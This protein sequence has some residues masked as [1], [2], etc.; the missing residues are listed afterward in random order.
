MA[1]RRRVGTST[2]MGNVCLFGDFHLCSTTSHS[3]PR[4]LTRF[5]SLLA[6]GLFVP[7][8]F[9]TAGTS[10][11]HIAASRVTT[12]PCI[13]GLLDDEQWRTASA[14]ST[15]VQFDPEEGAHPTERTTVRLMYDDHALYA[16]ILCY[17]SSPADIVEQLTRRYRS[18]EHTSELQSLAY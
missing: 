4:K 16:G 10:S 8:A 1:P 14:D 18:E 11:K 15:F 3:I 9:L 17:D 5:L 12:P 6:V 7:T 13:D 2:K